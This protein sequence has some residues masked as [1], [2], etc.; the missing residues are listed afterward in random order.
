MVYHRRNIHDENDW[1][2][3]NK[4]TPA[5]TYFYYFKAHGINIWT[6][7]RGVIVLLRDK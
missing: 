1:W 5:D 6:Q 2:A 4:H 3:P 7:H